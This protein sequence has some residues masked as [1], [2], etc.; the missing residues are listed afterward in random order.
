MTTANRPNTIWA[1][2]HRANLDGNG[3]LKPAPDSKGPKTG[4]N[5]ELLPARYKV[6]GRAPKGERGNVE[7]AL[8]RQDN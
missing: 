4:E 1:N 2:S 8:V 3:H 5:G 7:V 6:V